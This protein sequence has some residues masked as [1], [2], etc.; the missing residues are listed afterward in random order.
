[1]PSSIAFTSSTLI[2]HIILNLL[3]PTPIKEQA[4]L[5]SVETKLLLRRQIKGARDDSKGFLDSP[6]TN[7]HASSTTTD[8]L[9]LPKQNGIIHLQPARSKE[10]YSGSNTTRKWRIPD[11]EKHVGIKNVGNKGFP[12]ALN[13]ASGDAS[14]KPPFPTHHEGVGNRGFSRRRVKRREKGFNERREF[15]FSR[16]ILRDFP[17]PRHCVGKSPLNSFQFCIHRT[18]AER[19]GEKERRRRRTSPGRAFLLFRR[20]PSPTASPL[21]LVA[22]CH[23]R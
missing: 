21:F 13:N 7:L 23:F 14:G 9:R 3:K 11:V 12:D 6:A 20:R 10:F 18:E 19:R 16:R 2:F 15:P 8:Q 22:V 17:T 4:K 5:P 1:M